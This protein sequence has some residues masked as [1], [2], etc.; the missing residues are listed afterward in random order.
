MKRPRKTKRQRIAK[1]HIRT[2]RANVRH[3][4]PRTAKQFFRLSKE[5]QGEW[6]D[7]THV[8]SKMRANRV[9]LT[10]ASIEIGIDPHTVTRLGKSALRKRKN[11]QYTAKRSDKLL[12]I[13][14]IPTSD[15]LHEIVTRDSRQASQLGKYWSALAKYLQTGD[16]SKLEKFSR[17][18]KAITDADGKKIRLLFD[19]AKLDELASAGVLSFESIYAESI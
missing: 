9:S 16:V 6:N 5:A 18:R 2:Q 11:G 10:Q 13:L 3:V 1:K 17:R 8:I 4:A 19:F 12:R 14:A 7:V 15:G